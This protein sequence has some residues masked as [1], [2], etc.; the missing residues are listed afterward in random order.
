MDHIILL[1][2]SFLLINSICNAHNVPLSRED[3]IK[4]VNAWLVLIIF[5]LLL[6]SLNHHR[7]CV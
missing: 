5:V 2:F 1:I 6:I 7:V 4:G 3:F